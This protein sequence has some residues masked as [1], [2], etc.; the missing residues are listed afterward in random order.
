MNTSAP[1]FC[2]HG[3][4]DDP[5]DPNLKRTLD[6]MKLHKR[7]SYDDVLGRLIEDLHELNAETKQALQGAAQE[8]ESGKFRTHKQVKAELGL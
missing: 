4:N 3:D 5:A 8:I 6:A 2:A 1:I 7:E